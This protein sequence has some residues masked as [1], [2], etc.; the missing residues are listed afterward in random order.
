[1]DFIVAQ[2]RPDQEEIY[3][4][5]QALDQTLDAQYERFCNYRLDVSAL[6][7]PQIRFFV[8]RA[9]PTRT[10][11]GIGAVRFESGG[12]DAFAEIKRMYSVPQARGCGVGE[13]ILL[14]LLETIRAEGV[15][16]ARLETG[17]KLVAAVSLYKKHGF[18][19]IP[20]FGEYVATADTS[21][22]MEAQ[23]A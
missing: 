21:Y 3:P 11:L 15:T 13:A 6:L 23:L 7:A 18:R 16:V 9:Q 17:E 19:H 20:A 4:L 5:I 2:E 10:V 14:K 22:C 1:M 12:A 8:A